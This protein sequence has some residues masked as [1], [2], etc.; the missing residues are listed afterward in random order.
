MAPYWR[1][2][3][4]HPCGYRSP[5]NRRRP[6]RDQAEPPCKISRKKVKYS[7]LSIP[8]Y[9]V[10][11]D[12]K[13]TLTSSAEG[14][15][16]EHVWQTRGYLHGCRIACELS[17]HLWLTA[18][19]RD[20]R[21]TQ[22]GRSFCSFPSLAAPRQRASSAATILGWA[23]LKRLTKKYSIPIYRGISRRYQLLLETFNSWIVTV[24]Q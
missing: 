9:N 11:P 23:I 19:L 6:V 17:R 14:E 20:R 5:Q 3:F 7:E 4:G 18:P 22:T 10:W 24:A 8:P 15:H 2:K 12:K 21:R 1:P 16:A 13:S